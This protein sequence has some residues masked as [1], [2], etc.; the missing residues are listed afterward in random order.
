M[1]KI[2]ITGGAGFI[3]SNIAKFYIDQGLDVIILDNL[4]R[5]GVEYNL[6]WLKTQGDFKF[7]K[8]DIRDKKFIDE[9]FKNNQDI[10]VIFHEAAQV[11]VT[12]SVRDPELDFEV[13][14]LGTFNILEGMRKYLPNA[15]LIYAST[16]KVYGDL[17]YLEVIEKE[18]RYEFKDEKYK[19]GL[20]ENTNL[21]FHS[22]Y[23]CSKGAADQYVRDYYRIY[24][25]K[26]IVF[27]QSCIYGL[28]QIGLEDQGWVAWFIIRLIFDEP[29]TIYGT[30][31]QIRDILFVDDLIEAYDLA[32]KNINVSQGKIYNI[33]GGYNNSLSLLE[34]IDLF[35]EFFNKELN[36]SFSEWRPGDQKIFI[37][38]NSLLKRNLNWEPKTDYKTGIKKLYEWILENKDF[39]EIIVKNR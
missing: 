11:A 4:S 6:E 9:F 22:P 24:G 20:D 31:R 34:L 2:L 26:T 15:I 8:G 12:T 3:G 19:Y 37:S 13:N 5:K 29:V 32:I 7:V 27:R 33:G 30:G 1:K 23:G 25:L 18:K 38:N 17:S 36:Y 35:K 10:D 28:R 39:I 16:N 21:D 14:T